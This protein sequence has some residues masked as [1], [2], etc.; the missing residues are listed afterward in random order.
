MTAGPP[1]LYTSEM[2]TFARFKNIA[3]FGSADVTETS[4]LFLQAQEMG[5]LLAEAGVTVVNGGGPGTMLAAT[6]GARL[7]GG[8]SLTISFRP[9]DA[10]YFEGKDGINVADRDIEAKNYPERLGLLIEH[11]DAFVMLKGGT[12]TLSE[13]S[14]VWLMAHIHYGHH[15]P[16]VLVGEG[17]KELIAAAQK[18]FFIGP[19][20]EKVFRVVDSIHDAIPALQ[21][22]ESHLLQLQNDPNL[23]QV[24]SAPPSVLPT[25]TEQDAQRQVSDYI[26]TFLAGH[27]G[28]SSNAAAP[29]P[30]AVPPEHQAASP[31]VLPT[32]PP[33][34]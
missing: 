32:H 26:K 23:R 21:A 15:K 25:A 29:N 31:S 10:P 28:P 9:Q 17:W 13:W 24:E 5:K 6:R 16:F 20:E 8:Q 3:I 19:E 12:G 18:G 33:T 11:S 4:D 1:T 27:P 14:T 30:P 7:G 34:A 2:S 22:L